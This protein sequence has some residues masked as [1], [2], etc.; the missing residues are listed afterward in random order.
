MDKT[1]FVKYDEVVKVLQENDYYGLL[2][3]RLDKQRR[4]MVHTFA[5]I[6]WYTIDIEVETLKLDG[7]NIVIGIK[8]DGEE[9]NGIDNFK[10]RIAGISRTHGEK[11]KQAVR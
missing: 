10:R 5:S 9:V 6:K 11:R 7:E 1:T 3:K 2:V 4:R 8:F